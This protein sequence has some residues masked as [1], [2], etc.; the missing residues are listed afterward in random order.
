V[1]GENVEEPPELNA[2]RWDP[3]AE[4]RTQLEIGNLQSEIACSSFFLLVNG[5][6]SGY[7][8]RRFV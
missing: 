4:C 7:F 8:A 5:L 1:W 6:M 2:C 3:F